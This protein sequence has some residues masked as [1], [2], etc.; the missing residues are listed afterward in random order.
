[1]IKNQSLGLLYY[2][3]KDKRNKAGQAPI[4]LRL[5]VDGQRANISTNRYIEPERWNDEA[6]KVRGSSEESKSL[7]HYLDSLKNNVYEHHRILLDKG[8]TISAET[9]RNAILGIGE[10]RYT[11]VEAFA[12]HNK[13]M[14]EKI[15]I[16][17]SSATAVRYGTILQH[18]QEFMRSKYHLSDMPLVDLNYKFITD[19]EHYL[20]T[21]RN[22]NHNS[23][24]KYIRNFRKIINMAVANNWLVKDPFLQYKSRLQDTEFIYLTVEE[25]ERMKNKEISI[26]R[27]DLVRDL[28]VFSCYTGLAYVDLEKLTHNEIVIGIDGDRWIHTYRTKT[29][30][31]SN[32]PLL[33]EAL[34]IIEKYKGDIKAAYNERLLPVMSNQKL[35]SYLKELADICEINKNLTFHVARKTFGTTVLLNND[36]PIESVSRMLG[37]SDIRTTQK[38]YAKVLDRKVSDDMQKLRDKMYKQE[39]IK[40]V[41]KL[42]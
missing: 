29:E 32:I 34:A 20:K 9:L 37:H 19:L 11:L 22:C 1:M 25:L 13:Q 21:V 27:L 40:S 39:I 12:Y 2:L 36:V 6:D 24:L 26:S 3:R 41:V 14:N 33:P 38:S 31:K 35:N 18:I 28:F 16:D 10:K 42:M 8:K 30:V 5:T 4:Y 23:T 15:G 17:F 7:N